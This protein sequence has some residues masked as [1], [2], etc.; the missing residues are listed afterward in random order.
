MIRLFLKTRPKDYASYQKA[1][2]LSY[3][4]RDSDAKAQFDQVQRQYPNSRFV[5]ES[6][7]QKAN[8]DF[9]KGAYQVAI[10]EFT[11]LIQDKPNSSLIPAALLKRAIA[12]TNVQQ[13]DPAVADYKRI[14]DSYGNSEQAQSALLGIQNALSDAGRPEE[15]S[16]VL[17]QYKKSNPGS[18]DI[19]R[20]QFET[21]RIYTPAKNMRRRFSRYRRLCRSIQPVQI[22]TKPVIT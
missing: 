16:Q 9:E 3:L 4:G 8:V 12:Y 1:V 2:T 7:F 13:Y 19:E 20:V 15:F 5:D 18:T 21:R 10:Q 6:L 22:L 11:K 14:L 17:G